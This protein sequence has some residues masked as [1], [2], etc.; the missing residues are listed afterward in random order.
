M[1][2]YNVSKIV[3]GPEIYGVGILIVCTIENLVTPFRSSLETVRTSNILD[4]GHFTSILMT[5]A[6]LNDNVCTKM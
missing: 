5:I 2:G 1:V 3:P 4:T 6:T